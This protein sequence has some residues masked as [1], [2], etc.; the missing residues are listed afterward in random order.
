MDANTTVGVHQKMA[1][2]HGASHTKIKPPA[3]ILVFKAEIK[4]SGEKVAAR[5]VCGAKSLS[6]SAVCFMRRDNK[7]HTSDYVNCS[8]A[9][10]VNYFPESVHHGV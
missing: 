8:R 7:L 10:H 2:G 6:A 5:F 4:L 1:A 9:G 3:I